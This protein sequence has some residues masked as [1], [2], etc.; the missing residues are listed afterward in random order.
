MKLEPVINFM[1]AIQ[2]QVNMS[3]I[4]DSVSFGANDEK[5]CMEIR[6]R[7]HDVII[8]TGGVSFTSYVERSI[9]YDEL[10]ANDFS[11]VHTAGALIRNVERLIKGE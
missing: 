3:D 11:P 4:C 6:F 7:C 10:A 9:A 5:E 2:Y 1:H 8:P